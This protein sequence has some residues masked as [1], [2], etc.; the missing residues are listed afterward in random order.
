MAI[1]LSCTVPFLL[2]ILTEACKVTISSYSSTATS[3]TPW[4]NREGGTD[5]TSPPKT[6]GGGERFSRDVLPLQHAAA[7]PRHRIWAGGLPAH[8]G[9][10]GMWLGGMHRGHSSPPGWV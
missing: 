5:T 8:Q 10:A 3:G 7:L 1:S 4:E 2:C 9:Q 6:R